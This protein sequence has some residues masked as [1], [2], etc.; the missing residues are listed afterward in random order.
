MISRVEV[1][2]GLESRGLAP[3]QGGLIPPELNAS[4]GRPAGWLAG[5]LAVRLLTSTNLGRVH[6]PLFRSQ[7]N[8]HLIHDHDHADDA[9]ADAD[10]DDDDD[11]E[12]SCWRKRK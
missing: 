3:P 11:D 10:D 1:K 4:T 6:P 7:F 5:W 8:S 9:D 2:L 12:D